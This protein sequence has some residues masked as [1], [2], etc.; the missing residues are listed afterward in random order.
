M[1]PLR[2]G[3][4]PVRAATGRP[5]AGIFHGSPGGFRD[6][7]GQNHTERGS[8]GAARSPRPGPLLDALRSLR[9]TSLRWCSAGN[10][11]PA[12]SVLSGWTPGFLGA[13]PAHALVTAGC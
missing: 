7:P 3:P 11:T 5:W 1:S 10:V 9:L 8:L 12:G 13:K 4:V 2:P 6:G